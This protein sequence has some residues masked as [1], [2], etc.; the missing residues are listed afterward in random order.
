MPPNSLIINKSS[1]PGG[2]NLA[3]LMPWSP[4]NEPEILTDPPAALD[5]ARVLRQL[6]PFHALLGHRSA[7][8][9]PP[10]PARPAPSPESVPRRLAALPARRR[11]AAHQLI[12][13]Y[14]SPSSPRD[15]ERILQVATELRMIL[16][17]PGID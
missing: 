10:R 13:L 1:E 8:H 4:M 2:L 14:H 5:H 3:R 15:R 11:A 9:S 17:H 7:P 12:D 6:R 16:M